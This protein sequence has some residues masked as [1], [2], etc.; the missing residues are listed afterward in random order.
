MRR[1][2]LIVL[3][4]LA[5]LALLP[6]QSVSNFANT[7]SIASSG[8][9]SSPCNFTMQGIDTTNS[10]EYICPAGT[11]VLVG[12]SAPGIVQGTNTVRITADSSAI[13]AT[14]AATATT[15]FTFPALTA[16]KN[17]SFH[18]SGTTTQATAGAGIGIAIT[19]GTNAPTNLEAHAT[20]ATAAATTASTSS[21]NITTTTATAVYT[22]ATGTLTTQLPWSVD[23]SIEVGASVPALTI[24][25]FSIS[26]SD[27]VTVKRDSFCTLMP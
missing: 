21:G 25:F 13:T 27:A 19:A 12:G 20:V 3:F 2:L 4:V 9:P 22:G 11:W 18:C 26:A 14:T 5:L 7:V 23:G 16:N 15:I 8:A 10:N 6:G 1:L 17:Y 24:G